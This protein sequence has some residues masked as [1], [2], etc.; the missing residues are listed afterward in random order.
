MTKYRV[1]NFIKIE[2]KILKQT[3][4]QTTIFIF[5]SITKKISH[6]K[7]LYKNFILKFKNY[8]TL[9]NFSNCPRSPTN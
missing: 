2:M 1:Q 5:N 6:L 9:K 7:A 8:L 4:K 3:Y